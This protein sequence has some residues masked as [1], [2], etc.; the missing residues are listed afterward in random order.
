MS[1]TVSIFFNTDRTYLTL[2]NAEA[3]GLELEYLS[4]TEHRIDL[5]SPDTEQSLLG[6]S[7]L[8][9][10]LNQVKEM[11]FDRVAITM[12]AENVLVN[13]IPG[14]RDMNADDIRKLVNFEIRQ[15]FHQFR[16][17]DFSVSITPLAP[18]N[19]KKETML[20]VIVPNDVLKAA[21]GF[22]KPLSQMIDF[23]EISQLNAHSAFMYN[24]PEL[25]EK[26]I[27]IV[28]VQD[29]FIDISLS[30]A[31]T[32]GYYNL[33]SYDSIEQIGEVIEQEFQKILSESAETIDGAYFFGNKLTK[34]AML[35]CW[36][37]SMMLGIEAK[38][39]NPFRLMRTNLN[40]REKEY[41]SRTYQLYPPAVGGS[42]PLYH[43]RIKLI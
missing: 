7:E 11:N 40:E 28:S 17:Q 33:A 41:C 2:I 29:Q 5:E 10:L 43:K 14:N 25:A 21:T 18:G 38:R 23:I 35:A 20:C 9:E 1:K 19:D 4:A 42:L 12:P 24:Y 13:K 16:F 8:N 6:Q 30:K 39:L 15:N 32:P 31:G 37:T 3:D 26:N 22:I 34:D 36:E 27:A